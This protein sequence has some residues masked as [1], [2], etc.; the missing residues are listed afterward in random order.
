MGE[1]TREKQMRI[2]NKK[3]HI[4]SAG[5]NELCALM[6]RNANTQKKTKPRKKSIHR[7]GAENAQQA[8]L[9]D[10]GMR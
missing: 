5:W 1:I 6:Q 4:W 9:D 7:R 10:P 8:L 2:E 3:R